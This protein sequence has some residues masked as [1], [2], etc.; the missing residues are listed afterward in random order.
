M[1]AAQPTWNDDIAAL[2]SAPYWVAEPRRTGAGWAGC[3]GPYAIDLTSYDSVRASSVLIYRALHSRWM[4]L[5]AAPAEQWP[6]A[7]LEQLRAWV[8]QGWRR[9]AIDPPSPADRIP[10]PVE[11]PIATRIRRDLRALSSTELDVLRARID[12]V[13]ALG[14]AAPGAP[15]QVFFEL[16]GDWCLHYQE[17]F[18]LWHRAYLMQFEQRLGC[19]IPYWNWFARDA[20]IPGAPCAGL[21]RAFCDLTYVHPVTG[22]LRPNPL[23]FAAA[24]N[25][26]SKA[27]TG[28]APSG[29]DC[30]FVQRDPVLYAP[31]GDP[32]LAKKIA[33]TRLYQEQVAR[34]MQ[35][36]GFSHPQGDGYPWANIPTFDPPPP[37]SEYVYRDVNFDGAYEQPHDNYHGWV[38]PDMADNAYTAYDP[39]FFFYHS[40]IDRMFE[41][42]LRAHPT[43]QV[44]ANTPLRPFLG[45]LAGA[46]AYDD[47]RR[48]VYTTVGE[49]A[50]DSRG[51]GYDYAAPVD[52]DFA[53]PYAAPPA[54]RAAAVAGRAEAS[55]CPHHAA[56]APP[57]AGE[58]ELLVRFDGVRCTQDSYAI[59]AFLDLDAPTLA[60]VDADNPHY[61]GRLTRIGMG[62]SDDKGRCISHGV[63]RFLD[64]TPAARRLGRPPGMPCRLSLLVTR[65]PSR[66]RVPADESVMLP[67][68]AGDLAW[69]HAGRAR[70]GSAAAAVDSAHCCAP[71]HR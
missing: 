42:W 39:V 60:D 10:P 19:A 62:I 16:H 43:I 37:D 28:G 3:M 69:Y 20:S 40:N 31:A 32:A 38:G 65:L 68:F 57:P 9:A 48:F 30:R 61:I 24:R 52:P 67:G 22:E 55:A 64:A 27:C 4:P 33:M 1:T 23:R 13:F 35:F 47:P 53:G 70:R 15:G 29:V 8:N 14:D 12:D 49:L 45:P 41:L 2:F 71:A 25:G 59:D 18:L 17:A 44:T 58:T 6:D 66:E 36:T 21:P 7:A 50:K 11:R 46:I 63:S 34:A 56:P 5:G 26:H 51:L 54:A